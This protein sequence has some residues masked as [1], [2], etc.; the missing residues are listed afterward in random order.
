[1]E[2]RKITISRSYARKVNLGNYES[3]DFFS[4][5]GQELPIE[6]SIE[7]V[8]KQSSVLFLSACVD[9]EKAVTL[10]ETLRGDNHNKIGEEKFKKLLEKVR[11][12]V[13]IPISDFQ[14]FNPDQH[15]RVQ[16]K[17]REYKREVYKKQKEEKNGGEKQIQAILEGTATAD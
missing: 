6:T 2:D 15:K 1:M 13:P 7:E 11:A 16:D 8:Q 4:S 9:V 17:K 3:E 10:L 5:W 14:D 12:G